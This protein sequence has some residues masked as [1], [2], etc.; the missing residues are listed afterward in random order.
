MIPTR[1]LWIRIAVLALAG[2]IFDVDSA[3][4]ETP[5][6]APV[7]AI[8]E[9]GARI[10]GVTIETYGVVKAET[11][12]RY[13]SLHQGDTL[14]QNAVDRD[15]A[16]LA[17]LGGLHPRLDIEQDPVTGEVTLHWILMGKWLA[18][19]DH[20]PYGEQP[21]AVPLE[22]VGFVLTSPQFDRNG[23]YL[24]GYSQLT[25]R[26][27]LG[28]VLYTMPLRIDPV[29][30]RESDLVWSVYGARGVFRISQPAAV[31]I[32]SW[33][34]AEEVAY[35]IRGT[36]GT[37]VEAGFRVTRST[38]DKT[39]YIVAPTIYD[40]FHSPSRTTV[41]MAGIAHACLGPPTL[42]HPP[43][44]WIQYRA[45]VYDSIGGLGATNEYQSYQ[46]DVAH[47]TPVGNSTLAVR[48]A[49]YRT[50]GVIPSSFVVC[51]AGLHG[52]PKPFCGTDANIL[53]AEY[54]FADA[55]PGKWK[56]FLLTETGSS[57]VR[58]GDQ[59]FAPPTYHWHADSGIGVMYNGFRL[60]VT[61]GSAGNRLTYEFQGQLF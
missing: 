7:I 33:I 59:A 11:A 21:L 13:L 46:A 1:L 37:Q 4:A 41:L 51:A 5:K 22:G 15:Y 36:N 6:G 61:R 2:A 49:A 50:G 42:W 52:Y 58:G 56:F 24:S 14:E 26:T 43:Y 10:A 39:T 34:T 8:S 35:L 47:Y 57:R 9:A 20:P 54:R 32:Y 29:K 17:R 3:L 30:G 38:S 28:R 23:S 60:D 53:Q 31:N 48:A 25:Q 16:N 18:P 55:L 45:A 19:T 44:C 40:T 27:D 12:R